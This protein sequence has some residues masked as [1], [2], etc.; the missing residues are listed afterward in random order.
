M[1][2]SLTLLA[3]A[4]AGSAHAATLTVWTHF[5]DKAEVAWL[6]G[7]VKTYQNL[8]GNTVKVVNV[9]STRSSTSS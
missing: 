3:L 1:K 7:Q 5:N 6:A 8:S 9:P 4:L 2:R